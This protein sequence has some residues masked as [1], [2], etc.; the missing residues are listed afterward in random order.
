MEGWCW[1]CAWAC[2]RRW[3]GGVGLARGHAHADGGLELGLREGILAQMEGRCRACACMHI[4]M[5]SVDELEYMRMNILLWTSLSDT[6]N[7]HILCLSNFKFFT[8]DQFEWILNYLQ[9]WKDN[10][11][12]A[13]L[14]F[15]NDTCLI[16]CCLKKQIS[17]KQKGA[18]FIAH[19]YM[20]SCHSYRF[21]SLAECNWSDMQITNRREFST[22]K[23]WNQS[24]IP[25]I[26]PIT[27]QREF[28]TWK[29]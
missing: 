7:D 20:I 18:I 24:E 1:A 17:K 5:D 4:L 3:K 13:V 23:C 8:M 28:S 2:S 6:F 21:L 26:P 27:N 22:R 29:C 15:K 10:E 16:D 11:W 12:P 25:L 14:F 19:L 9:M